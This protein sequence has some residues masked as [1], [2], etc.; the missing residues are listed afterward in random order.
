MKEG[1]VGVNTP[2]SFRREPMA[3]FMQEYADQ[4]K[5][6]MDLS[7]ENQ[8]VVPCLILLYSGMDAFGFLDSNEDYATRQTFVD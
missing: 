1:I 6:G 3:N 2:I 8:I 7:L 4:I 5:R